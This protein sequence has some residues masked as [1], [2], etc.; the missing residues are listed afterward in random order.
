MRVRAMLGL[1]LSFLVAGEVSAQAMSSETRARAMPRSE[2]AFGIDQWQYAPDSGDP[3]GGTTRWGLMLVSRGSLFGQWTLSE[4][5]SALLVG[6]YVE[7]GVGFYGATRSLSA[8]ESPQIRLPFQVGVQLGKLTDGGTQ[9]VG[10]VGVAGGLSASAYSGPFIG[11]RL[12][13]RAVGL[14]ASQTFDRSASITSAMLRWYPSTRSERFNVA[15]R[16]E[17]HRYEPTG[18]YSLTQG[19]TERSLMLVVSAER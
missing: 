1:V 19:A 12:K 4:R 11:A 6:D 18:L 10:R 7:T 16:Y 3:R 2:F 8:R 9:V 15:L 17:S 14:E 5:D 13:H